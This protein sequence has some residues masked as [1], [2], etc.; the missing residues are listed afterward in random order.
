MQALVADHLYVQ[1]V[2]GGDLQRAISLMTQNTAGATLIYRY[3]NFYHSVG[4]GV[5]F[6]IKRFQIFET[7]GAAG[8]PFANP[9]S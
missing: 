1:N 6:A 5:H 8:N 3:S 4:K 7:E 9:V 2:A